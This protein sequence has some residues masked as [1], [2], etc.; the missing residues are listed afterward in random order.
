MELQQDVGYE[1]LHFVQL[2]L[3]GNPTILEVLWSPLVT[4][5]NELGEELRNIRHAFLDAKA[6]HAAHLGYAMS[7][8]KKIQRSITDWFVVLHGYER[9]DQERLAHNA[10]IGKHYGAWIRVLRQGIGLLYDQDFDPRLAGWHKQLLL[11][12][13][14]NPSPALISKAEHIISQEEQMLERA[15]AN[16]SFVP[17]KTTIELYLRKAYS[18]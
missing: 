17:D 8:R 2:L 11:E 16:A 12:L 15:A 14:Q 18:V 9:S 1:L 4:Q 10:R 13:K 7:Q 3:K 5:S 6:I